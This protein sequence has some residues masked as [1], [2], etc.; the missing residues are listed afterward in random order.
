MYPSL[1]SP[2]SHFALIQL[3]IRDIGALCYIAHELPNGQLLRD[4]DS[5]KANINALYVVF[6]GLA[7]FFPELFIERK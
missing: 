1:F 4:F 6:N 3:L 2:L 7:F 5:F